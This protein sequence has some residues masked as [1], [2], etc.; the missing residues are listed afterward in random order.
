M[1]RIKAGLN[2]NPFTA[3]AQRDLAG[4]QQA[5][6]N[7]AVLGTIGENATAATPDV[8]NSA[9]TRIGQVFDDVASRNPI[10]Y[11]NQLQNALAG[12]E[13]Q[14][15]GE[16]QSGQFKVIENKLNEVLNKAAQG[17]GAIDGAAYQNLKTSLDR[18]SKG[19]DRGVGYWARQMRDALDDGLQRSAQGNDYQDLLQARNQWRNMRQIEGAIG[20]D[21]NGNISPNKLANIVMQKANRAQSVYGQG[22][23][24]LV[25]LAQ[26][27][28]NVLPDKV[29]NS[30]T[31]ARILAQM[32]LTGGL[33]GGLGYMQSGDLAGAAK[34]ATF[35]VAVP[36]LLQ[37]MMNNPSAVN[38]L[39][40]GLA[41]GAA[42]TVLESPANNKLLSPIFKHAP[43][44][45]QEIRGQRKPAAAY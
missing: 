10:T 45:W 28:K 34:G 25:D 11:D 18:L 15:Q 9:K 4:Q 1:N 43:N 31:P 16:L 44:V 23:Q 40:Q 35:G 17:N 41:P 7:R 33:G 37:M 32:A 13:Q 5:S 42:R 27:G 36:K 21:G 26:A 8:M 29:P 2:D 38:Y 24:S 39:T 3:G 20:A 22:P 6:F 30:G 19:Q 14:A 12:I